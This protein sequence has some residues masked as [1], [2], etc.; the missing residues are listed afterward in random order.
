[1]I[2]ELKTYY[3][4]LLISQYRQK[5]RA[6][7]TVEVLAELFLIDQLPKSVQDS[8][9]LENGEGVQLDTMAKYA[10]ISREKYI[11]NRIPDAD[12]LNILKLAFLK[13]NSDSNLFN[14]KNQLKNYLNG[15]AITIRD[16]QDMTVRFYVDSTLISSTLLQLIIDE[17]LLFRPMGVGRSIYYLKYINKIFSFRTYE[18]KISLTFG[19]NS[20]Y[21]NDS[22]TSFLSYDA[23]KEI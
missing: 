22:M 10:G 15:A 3:A 13:N 11:T 2:E 9:S 7:A 16:H 4:D 18:K 21:N 20:I 23:E 5:T 19:F 1:M 6:R 14:I 8:Y 12:F 17:E